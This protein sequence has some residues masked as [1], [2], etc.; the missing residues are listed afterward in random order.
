MAD[1]FDNLLIASWRGI[2]FPYTSI[3]FQFQHDLVIHRPLDRD[4][5]YPEPMGRGPRQF[6]F[7]I[8]FLNRLRG[9]DE[10]LFPTRYNAF[11]QAF[12]DKSQGTLIDPEAGARQC[13]PLS[14]AST[15]AP[16]THRNGKIVQAVFVETNQ[17]ALAD[18]VLSTPRRA[19]LV[20]TA[21]QLDTFSATLPAEQQPNLQS[22]GFS[23][24]D[25][26]G[27]KLSSVQRNADFQRDLAVRKADQV[28]AAARSLRSP[29]P[30]DAPL[31]DVIER[32]TA[33]TIATKQAALELVRPTKF[34]VIQRAT[35]IAGAAKLVRN[36]PDDLLA[37]NQRLRGRTQIA[38]G[39]ALK[40]YA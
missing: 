14:F 19:A 27:N 21:Q 30:A 13:F 5:A 11:L 31:L 8:P 6:T 18:D 1:I 38:A 12:E 4:G 2:E 36:S 33:A 29:N 16:S 3:P 20:P 37:L 25:D 10:E 15:L 35:T 7:E 28:I 23:S 40:H 17:E 22:L 39:F 32:F 34:T 24:F 9:F 26:F